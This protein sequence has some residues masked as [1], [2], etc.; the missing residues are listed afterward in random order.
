MI[1]A[2]GGL[3]KHLIDMVFFSQM[4]KVLH[5]NQVHF[6]KLQGFISMSVQAALSSLF[7]NASNLQ[8]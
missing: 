1:W 5:H 8:L 6:I 2:I 7:F 4:L 3:F